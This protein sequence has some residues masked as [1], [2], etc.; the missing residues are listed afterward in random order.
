MFHMQTPTCFNPLLRLT[1]PTVT[2]TT[3]PLQV[4][5]QFVEVLGKK[6]DKVQAELDRCHVKFCM[7]CILIV[8]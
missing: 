4:L 1:F 8:L 5:P 7:P 2:A 3:T 6:V